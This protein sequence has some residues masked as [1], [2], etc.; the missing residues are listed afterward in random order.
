MSGHGDVR[1]FLQSILLLSLLVMSSLSPAAFFSCPVFT[2]LEWVWSLLQQVFCLL[3]RFP[4]GVL[5]EARQVCRKDF[6]NTQ[7]LTIESEA[8]TSLP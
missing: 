5:Q 3:Q 4:T 6:F 8:L 2:L 1:D 7:Y